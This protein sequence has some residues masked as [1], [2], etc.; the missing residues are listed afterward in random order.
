MCGALK[1]ISCSGTLA[2]DMDF[3]LHSS[4]PDSLLFSSSLK[5]KD[6][7]IIHFGND[8]L[9]RING[10][11]IYDA[12][13]GTHFMRKIEI[14]NDNPAYTPLE[15]ISHYL[16]LCIM[17]SEDP[18]FMEHRGFIPEAMRE[19]LAQDYKEK[20]FA[21]GGSTISMQLVKN[22]FLKREKTI[23]RKV[24]EA[25]IVYLIENLQ[26]VSKQRMMEVYLN[27]IE[28]GPNIYGVGEAAQFYFHKSALQLTLPE[29]VFLAAIIPRPRSFAYQFDKSGQVKPYIKDF[30][31]LI[32]GRLV[33]RGLINES[34]TAGVN[35][36]VKLTGPAAR[37]VLPGDSV[38]MPEEDSIDME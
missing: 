21:R 13:Q 23:S 29:C 10:P 34:D 37:L 4:Q 36:S 11:F 1:G 6:F 2:Y 3:S 26:L 25:L 15:R 16:P 12:Y 28:W 17:T 20:R 31:K 9:A 22:V 14:G 5:R 27:V 8:N 18:G 35:P 38:L 24:E 19:S 32:T 30:Y 33:N 7:H